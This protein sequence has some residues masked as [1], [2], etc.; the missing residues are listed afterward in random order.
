MRYQRTRRARRRRFTFLLLLLLA[1]ATLALAGAGA[2]HVFRHV[3]LPGQ[4]QRII[5]QL[6]FMRALMAP[7]PPGGTLPTPVPATG[8]LSAADLLA[9]LPTLA[10]TTAVP[11]TPTP[12]PTHTE[13]PT[14]TPVVATASPVAET[15]TPDVASA[16]EPAADRTRRTT[17]PGRPAAVSLSGFTHIMQSWNNCGPANLGMA[18]SYY[19]RA[20]GQIVIADRLKPGRED[21][22]VNP[23]E[24]V[25][26]VNER[27]DLKAITRMGGNLEVLR[28]LVA[29]EMAVIVETGF[30]PE[31]YDWLGHY[32]TLS[33][34]NDVAQEFHVMDSFLGAGADGAGMTESYRQLDGNWKPFNR[35]FVVVYRPEQ[36]AQLRSLL[37]ELATPAGAAEAALKTARDEVRADREDAFA[38]FNMGSSLTRL[39]HHEE[40]AAAFDQARRV[41][42]LPWRMTWYQ[43]GPFEAYFEAGRLDDVLAL[44]R[45]NMSNGARF[46]E[47]TWF[48]QGRVL[49]ARGD[50]PAAR[51]AFNQALQL[52]R[53]YDAA[54]EALA[55]L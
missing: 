24:M 15:A 12:A 50:L 42:T 48:W 17:G 40:A 52:N 38:W 37:G 53:Y 5:D 13:A 3:L 55:E 8:A 6:P 43:F 46:V 45:V 20:S 54:R 34:Y 30:L 33:G 2:V 21:K 25:A 9:A 29:A 27:T 35:T 36:E 22:N 1:A 44:V 10:A 28:Q 18:L 47:E 19:G 4:Q 32:Q 14:F 16:R 26:Y 7:T 39:G 23:G 31:G 41:G 51:N 49:Q 11:A